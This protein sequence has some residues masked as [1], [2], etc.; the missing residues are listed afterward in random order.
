MG[1]EV[2]ATGA[3]V[4]GAGI[5]SLAV[6]EREA[7]QAESTSIRSGS[8]FGRMAARL[9]EAKW[10]CN[11]RWTVEL[12]VYFKVKEAPRIELHG[13]NGVTRVQSISLW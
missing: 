9:H 8:R 4:G 13:L 5:V 7:A 6:E 11:L 12:Q 3:E 10:G 2:G 1:G